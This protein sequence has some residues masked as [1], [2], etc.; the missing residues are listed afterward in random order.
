MGLMGY[1]LRVVVFSLRI[2]YNSVSL[3]KSRLIVFHTSSIPIR[4]TVEMCYRGALGKIRIKHPVNH[5][6]SVL[7]R[8]IC[9]PEDKASQKI[10][11]I[12]KCT[13]DD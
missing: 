7:V 13:N 10:S 11:A 5:E 12:F 9:R 6:W 2:Y 3:Q 1:V 4:P 8:R